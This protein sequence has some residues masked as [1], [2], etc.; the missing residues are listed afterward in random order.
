MS[1]FSQFDKDPW[2]PH[3]YFTSEF[4]LFETL[5]V[6]QGRVRCL[7][8]HINRIRSSADALNIPIFDDQLDNTLSQAAYSL[9][10]E[11]DCALR[12]SIA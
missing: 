11:G 3:R 12:Y 10:D 1:E 6:Y 5:R 4:C 2:H 8:A 9:R 7:S